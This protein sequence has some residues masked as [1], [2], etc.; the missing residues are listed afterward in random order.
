MAGGALAQVV[1]AGRGSAPRRAEHGVRADLELLGRE[2]AARC[3]RMIFSDVSSAKSSGSPW[4][5]PAARVDLLHRR[6]LRYVSRTLL[7]EVGPRTSSAG[8][9]ERMRRSTSKETMSAQCA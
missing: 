6:G 7:E 9:F 1:L 2:S 3:A 5:M 8:D 4:I